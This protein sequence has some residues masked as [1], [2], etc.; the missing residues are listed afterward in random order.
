MG[1]E[2]MEEVEVKGVGREIATAMAHVLSCLHLEKI[3]SIANVNSIILS[4]ISH[5]FE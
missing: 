4:M 1:A 5:M 3:Q 2:Q